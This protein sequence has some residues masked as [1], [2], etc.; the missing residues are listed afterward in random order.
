MGNLVAYDY[1]L[2]RQWDSLNHLNQTAFSS[3]PVIR[4][5]PDDT[6]G[7]VIA[8][9]NASIIEF[10]RSN[11]DIVWE[12]ILG[13]GGIPTGPLITENGGIVFATLNGPVYLYDGNS[14]LGAARGSL[15]ITDASCGVEGAGNGIFDSN[16]VAASAAG[17]AVYVNARCRLPDGPVDPDSKALIARLDVD[18][19]ESGSGLTLKYFFEFNGPSFAS[20]L[21][22]DDYIYFDGLRIDEPGIDIIKIRDTGTSFVQEEREGVDT[23]PRA[24][25]ALDPRVDLPD[26]PSFWHP[27]LGRLERRRLGDLTLIETIY[28]GALIGDMEAG[29]LRMGVLTIAG[30]ATNPVLLTSA[31]DFLAQIG[32]VVA[33]NLLDG[34]ILWKVKFGGTIEPGLAFDR[35]LSQF[36]ILTDGGANPRVIFTGGVSNADGGAYAAGLGAP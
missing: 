20:P 27:I 19:D 5:N 16:N 3:M 11:G 18:P 8:A 33:I 10:D 2:V 32:Y 7:N 31:T 6:N 36:P 1:D 35:V 13:D 34:Q 9:D 26:E 29:L 25:F 28:V 24:S 14:A 15:L 21:I 12:Q 17:N 23:S 4:R 22:V 30:D